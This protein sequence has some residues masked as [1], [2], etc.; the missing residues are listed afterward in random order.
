MWKIRFHFIAT[1]VEPQY[2]ELWGSKVIQYLPHANPSS[3][4]KKNFKKIFQKFAQV[5]I[6][7]YLCIV[8][9]KEYPYNPD[10]I[11]SQSGE[12]AVKATGEILKQYPQKSGYV[13]VILGKGRNRCYTAV[14][15]M[16]CVTF[17]GFPTLNE[18]YVDHI[19][20]D[21]ANNHADNLHWVS[22]KGNARNPLTLAKRRKKENLS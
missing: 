9:W 20:T 8:I 2:Q 1:G 3:F 4:P 22:P 16:V 14:H 7:L 17:H 19:D 5:R 11:V 15:K 10:Y 12:V 6:N 21:R 18:Y 13:F